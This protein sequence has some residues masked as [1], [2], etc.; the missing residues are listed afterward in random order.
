M[1]VG[2]GAF[3]VE[4]GNITMNMITQLIIEM[5]IVIKQSGHLSN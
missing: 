4:W 1:K 2:M 3:V 5:Y